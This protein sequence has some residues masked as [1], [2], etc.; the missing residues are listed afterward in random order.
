MDKT[1]SKAEVYVLRHNLSSVTGQEGKDVVR[2]FS[3]FGA[4]SRAYDEIWSSIMSE[5]EYIS[6]SPAE[7]TINEEGEYI[8]KDTML[9]RFDD[10]NTC[11]GA[12]FAGKY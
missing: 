7:L 9:V 8:L 4:G 2:I 5:D 6:L 12:A 1:T 10:C 3:S 11:I